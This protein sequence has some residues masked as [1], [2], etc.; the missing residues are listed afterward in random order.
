MEGTAGNGGSWQDQRR[1]VFGRFRRENSRAV[2]RAAVTDD[3]GSASSAERVELFSS[4][5][6]WRVSRAAHAD[7]DK[8][9]GRARRR[10][11]PR[12]RLDHG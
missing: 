2:F 9:A 3:H 1:D 8:P 5:S 10:G 6:A 7:A 11:I 4:R 12:Q